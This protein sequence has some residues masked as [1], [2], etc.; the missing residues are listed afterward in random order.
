MPLAVATKSEADARV[1]DSG[2]LWN[3]VFACGLRGVAHHKATAVFEINLDPSTI[4]RLIAVRRHAVVP[5]T[6]EIQ[7]NEIKWRTD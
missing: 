3:A 6:I 2:D 1:V 4:F 5:V 7:V